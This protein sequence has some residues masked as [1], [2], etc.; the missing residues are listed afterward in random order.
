MVD[1]VGEL[2]KRSI[3]Q[4]E[5]WWVDFDPVIGH[6][7]ADRRPALVVSTEE[8]HQSAYGLVIVMPLTT[9]DHGYPTHVLLP[10]DTPGLRERSF[11]QTEQI[12]TVSTLRVHRRLGA[13]DPVSLNNV[14]Y[15]LSTILG[16]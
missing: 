5:L 7:Q 4:G 2:R 8:F 6:E 15:A 12:R 1:R 14:F 3:A 11:V 9:S 16:L 10:D 13:I